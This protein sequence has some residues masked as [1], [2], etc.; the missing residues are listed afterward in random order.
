MASKLRQRPQRP[1]SNP[2]QMRLAIDRIRKRIG[3]V[4][5]LDPSLLEIW[6]PIVDALQASLDDTL[7][8]AFGHDTVEYER[9]RRTV[10][11]AAELPSFG[12]DTSLDQY[13]DYVAKGKQ[14]VLI[15]L[16]QAISTLEEELGE[17][18]T[19][20]AEPTRERPGR[21]IIIG[22]GRSPLWRELKDFLNDRLG[23][24]AE[25][26]NSVSVAGIPTVSRL[27]EMLDGAAFAFL[28]MT[29]EDQQPDGKSRARENVAHEAGLFQGRLGFA[30][31]II[32]LE[33][34]CEE[35]SNIH[36]LGQIRFPKG[37][38]AAKFEEVRLVLEREG[39]GGLRSS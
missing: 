8:R 7:A 19:A 14:A 31:A 10:D 16:K 6:S 22:H 17:Q 27:T 38:I 15:M 2:A 25:E 24:V 39:V 32:L 30:R 33:D 9:Y 11:W 26:F 28:I 20:Y 23:L 36:G 35:F 3:E 18:I 13:R 12:G 29:A 5:A 34:G 4:E 37:N 1:Q 21:S